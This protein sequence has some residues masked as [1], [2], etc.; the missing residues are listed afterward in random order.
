M[1]PMRRLAEEQRLG[2][3]RNRTQTCGV[4]ERAQLLEPAAFVV[5][6]MGRIGHESSKC[7]SCA[8]QL[9][10]QSIE[11]FVLAKSISGAYLEPVPSAQEAA[12]ADASNH[13][14][15]EIHA[16]AATGQETVLTAEARRLIQ[17]LHRRFEPQRRA[18]LT[19]RRERQGRFDAGGLPDFRADTRSIRESPRRCAAM[20]RPPRE[21]R[22]PALGRIH[23]G[24]RVGRFGN[25]TVLRRD[26]LKVLPD[27]CNRS[28]SS[29]TTRPRWRPTSSRSVL[30]MARLL[31]SLRFGLGAARFSEQALDRACGVQVAPIGADHEARRTSSDCRRSPAPVARRDPPPAVVHVRHSHCPSAWKGRGFRYRGDT[32]RAASAP[33]PCRAGC[34]LSVAEPLPL[35]GLPA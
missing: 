4:A 2:R 35:P 7:S 32:R 18:L 1:E 20:A 29:P 13:A 10:M 12:M 34:A 16:P 11:T 15:L 6:P 26:R 19:A 28:S 22:A 21:L 3:A 9:L 24:R 23:G 25:Q 33:R 17:E 31:P 8:L 5:E 30:R 14:A 27:E